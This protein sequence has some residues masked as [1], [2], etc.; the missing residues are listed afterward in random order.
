MCRFDDAARVPGHLGA[1]ATPPP[2]DRHDGGPNGC[3][4]V[5]RWG[6]DLG[7]PLVLGVRIRL[8]CQ[9]FACGL[10]CTCAGVCSTPAGVRPTLRGPW[11]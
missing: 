5:N 11:T 3:R 10:W 9:P 1:V 8:L 2:C 4:T 6:G 7:E